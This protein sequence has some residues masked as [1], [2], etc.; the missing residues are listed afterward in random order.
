MKHFLLIFLSV[1]GFQAIAQHNVNNYKYVIVPAQYSFLAENDQYQLNSLTKFLFNKYGFEAY[2]ENEELPEDLQNNRCLGMYVNLLS[3]NSLFKTKLKIELRDCN[4]NVIETSKQGETREKDYKQAFQLALRDAFE[5]F[6]M[7]DYKYIPVDGKTSMVKGEK[8]A[9]SQEEDLPE[10]VVVTMHPKATEIDTDTSETPI[11]NSEVIVN[12][13]AK[14]EAP[15]N[16]PITTEDIL[17]AQPIENGFQIIDTQPKKVMV[18][19]YS[20]LKD[21]FIVEG[22]NAILYKKGGDWYIDRYE[23]GL[24]SKK[25]NIKF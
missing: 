1:M 14:E 3:D 24:E 19:Y 20:S 11:D 4:N 18:I 13:T 7:M 22:G 23:Q 15:I 17:Y 9:D 21:V 12:D 6:M 25:I 5:T 16:E 2:L 8:A 10:E